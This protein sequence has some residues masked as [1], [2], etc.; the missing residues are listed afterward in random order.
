MAYEVTASLLTKRKFD[1][2]QLKEMKLDYLHVKLN[3]IYKT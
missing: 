1:K 2:I 3:D